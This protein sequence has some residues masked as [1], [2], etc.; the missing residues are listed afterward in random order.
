MQTERL[1][2]LL[3]NYKGI[4]E[5]LTPVLEEQKKLKEEIK[6]ALAETL[7]DSYAAGG[8]S[9]SRYTSTRITYQAKKLEEIFTEDQ[10]E[11]AKKVTTSEAVRISI[12]K[13]KTA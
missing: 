5:K 6:E 9:V 7:L 11:P 12:A 1:E 4:Q 2:T 8:V 13:D 3:A 10:L